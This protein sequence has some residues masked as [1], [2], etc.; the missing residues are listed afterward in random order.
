M[1]K[2]MFFALAAAG[3]FASCTSDDVVVAD[4]G[5]NPAA[6]QNLDGR[7]VIKIGL[8]NVS[9]IMTKGTGTVGGVKNATNDSTNH[10]WKGQAFRMFMF[11]HA[12]NGDIKGALTFNLAT[13]DLKY[14]DNTPADVFALFNND[15]LI[16]QGHAGM[17]AKA[18]DQLTAAAPCDKLIRYYPNE[19]KQAYDFIAYRADTTVKIVNNYNPATFSYDGDSL[20]AIFKIDGSQDVLL[21]KSSAIKGDGTDVTDPT[22]KNNSFSAWSSRHNIYPMLNF[23]HMLTRFTVEIQAGDE[24]T[25]ANVKVD[26]IA[27][28]SKDSL[29]MTLAYADDQ[30][31]ALDSKRIVWA[32]IVYEANYEGDLDHVVSG[33]AWLKMKQ[34]D[35]TPGINA[36]SVNL[37]KLDAD[38]TILENV[39]T[40]FGEALMVNPGDSVYKIRVYINEDLA[41]GTSLSTP[42]YASYV[43]GNIKIPANHTYA[44]ISTSYNVRLT[45]FG[46]KIVTV[47]TKLEP[48]TNG[49]DIPVN[50]QDNWTIN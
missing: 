9:T 14:S 15:S 13:N 29:A 24:V 41:N 4:E 27:I 47:E 28:F 7:E 32:P 49:G 17:S 23:Q 38:Q 11:K 37:V 45:I 31:H 6:Q 8:G 34:R 21:A 12:M 33:G 30:N 22:E 48:W 40:K 43:E 44:Q 46:H 42:N 39:F 20:V 19:A 25:A 5:Q 35:T 50:E 2:I 1:K 3:L 16:S 36:D 10:N 18:I 26:S